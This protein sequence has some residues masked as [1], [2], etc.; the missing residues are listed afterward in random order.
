MKPF[1]I[2][3]ESDATEIIEA[4]TIERN[5]VLENVN[6]KEDSGYVERI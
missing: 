5:D 2:I 3:F 1:K 4:D 6:V